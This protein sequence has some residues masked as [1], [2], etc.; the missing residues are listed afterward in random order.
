M[1]CQMA[2]A[3]VISLLRA[4]PMGSSL[5]SSA[6]DFRM[7]GANFFI[8]M[9]VFIP[10]WLIAAPARCCLRSAMLRENTTEGKHQR[11]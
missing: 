10:Y 8:C 11:S 7:H 5:R 1:L 2:Y 9:V 4:R 6:K 3:G